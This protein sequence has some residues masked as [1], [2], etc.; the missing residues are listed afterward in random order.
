MTFTAAQRS[1]TPGAAGFGGSRLLELK[2]ARVSSEHHWMVT[3]L[4]Q[5]GAC[6]GISPSSRRSGSAS[7]CLRRATRA[8][9]SGHGRHHGH[10]PVGFSRGRRLVLGGLDRGDG[11]DV[12][13]DGRGEAFRELVGAS[14]KPGL[15]VSAGADGDGVR[16]VLESGSSGSSGADGGTLD[17]LQPDVV[18]VHVGVVSPFS[19]A[20]AR[21][22]VARGLPCRRRP[23]GAACSTAWFR[24]CAPPSAQRAG[25]RRPRR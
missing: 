9:R 17:S 23:P 22:A 6:R 7:C 8:G 21:L 19:F 15:L 3:T 11:V 1:F 18:H 20:V 5:I 10:R 14:G 12:G 16:R 13:V 25:G 24:R 4:G 2:L